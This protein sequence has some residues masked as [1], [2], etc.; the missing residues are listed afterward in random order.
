MGIRDLVNSL[1]IYS[2]N[3]VNTRVSAYYSCGKKAVFREEKRSGI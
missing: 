1:T 3:T 2:E